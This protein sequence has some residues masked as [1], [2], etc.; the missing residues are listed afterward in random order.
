[1]WAWF[2]RLIGMESD[3]ERERRQM[4]ED[5]AYLFERTEQGQRVWRKWKEQLSTRS[6]DVASQR[7]TDFNEGKKEAIREI[8]IGIKFYHSGLSGKTEVITERPKPT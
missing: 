8:D 2:K 3:L 6:F 4:A 5:V 1:M 7:M